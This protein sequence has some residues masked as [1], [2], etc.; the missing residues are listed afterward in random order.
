MRKA[1]DRSIRLIQRSRLKR[2]KRR[3]LVEAGDGPGIWASSNGFGWFSDGFWTGFVFGLGIF[4]PDL[5]SSLL[6]ILF[7][8]FSSFFFQKLKL[9]N[10]KLIYK[11]PN[12]LKIL[13]ISK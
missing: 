12:Y 13:I 1:L 7:L 6:L 4:G 10:P 9:K 5:V 3:R 8:F 11:N 2:L